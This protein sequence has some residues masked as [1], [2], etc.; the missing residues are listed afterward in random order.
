LNTKGKLY[1]EKKG[2]GASHSN[3]IFKYSNPAKLLIPNYIK[4]CKYASKRN[5]IVEKSPKFYE[6]IKLLLR[7]SP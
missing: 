5:S 2:A 1:C 7:K 3:L 4:K 6:K